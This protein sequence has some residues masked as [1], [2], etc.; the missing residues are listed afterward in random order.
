MAKCP[1]HEDSVGVEEKGELN[2]ITCPHCGDYR[3]SNVALS[4]LQRQEVPPA[5][6]PRAVA[7]KRLISSR[8]ARALLAG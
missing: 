8:D 1:F 3:I 2:A 7:R 4:E 5:G 6:W